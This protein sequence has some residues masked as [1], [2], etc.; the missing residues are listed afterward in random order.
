MQPLVKGLTAANS[1]DLDIRL[2]FSIPG[3]F[4]NV[5]SLNFQFSIFDKSKQKGPLPPILLFSRQE[6]IK[7][8]QLRLLVDCTN[9]DTR[10]SIMLLGSTV[11]D[12]FRELKIT[13]SS[14]HLKS[15]LEDI[16]N[17]PMLEN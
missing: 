12:S 2:M 16:N 3:L 11:S 14:D 9:L 15:V 10:I 7:L 8:Q 4:P 5:E 6:L 17:A 1:S 13:G